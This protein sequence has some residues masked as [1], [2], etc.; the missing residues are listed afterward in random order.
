ML[1]LQL[2]VYGLD[3]CWII[4]DGTG[5][6]GMLPDTLWAALRLVK[7]PGSI[8]VSDALSW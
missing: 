8:F 7:Y 3:P 2:S 5:A 4:Q 6:F 1:E